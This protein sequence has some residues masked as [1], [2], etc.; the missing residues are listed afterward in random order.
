MELF[1]GMYG[2]LIATLAFGLA[3]LPLF[4]KTQ[5]STKTYNLTFTSDVERGENHLAGARS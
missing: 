4:K 2:E 5:L 1:V 3:A